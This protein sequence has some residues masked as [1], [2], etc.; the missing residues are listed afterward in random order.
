LEEIIP[1]RV[2]GGHGGLSKSLRLGV[3]S[4]RYRMLSFDGF[5]S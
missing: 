4:F 2:G 3:G 5:V 1:A